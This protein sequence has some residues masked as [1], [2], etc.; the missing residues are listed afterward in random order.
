MT[1][2]LPNDDQ[3]QI[4]VL[5]YISVSEKAT[6]LGFQPLI[7]LTLLPQNFDCANKPSD[8][9]YASEA[10]TLKK[11]FRMN[12]IECNDLSAGQPDSRIIVQ[13]SIDWVAPLMF[14][15]ISM[16]SENSNAVS[17]A[18]SVIGNYLT[19][20]FKG[21][22]GTRKVKLSFVIDKSV[23]RNYKRVDFEGSIKDLKEIETT[24]LAIARAK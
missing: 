4:D 2:A 17:L 5:D 23:D 6:A 3:L 16:V 7:G 9:L 13:K 1:G 24:I 14:L 18:L 15:S 19:D 21:V 10:A 11:L 8:F 22:S 12:S 20:F